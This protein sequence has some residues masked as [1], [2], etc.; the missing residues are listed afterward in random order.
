[1]YKMKPILRLDNVCKSFGGVVAADNVSFSVLPGEIHGLIGPNGAGKS[2]IMNLISGIYTVDS[3]DV[4]LNEEKITQM[5]AYQRAR[6]G[7]GRTFQTPRFLQRSNI[8]DNLLLG[9]DLADQMGY[10]RS[11][12]GKKGY[13]FDD[14]L[15]ELM[16]YVE[17]S[18]DLND[19]ITSLSYGQ[20]KQLEIIR[21]LL[22]H[23]KVMLVDEPA[24]GLNRKEI[25]NVMELLR[26]AAKDRNIGILLIEHSMDM[27]M[28]VCEEIVVINF[29]KVIGTGTPEV[30]SN[31]NAVIEAYLGR[32]RNA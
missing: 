16:K 25:D 14:E 13:A 6:N 12:I 24:A 10:W 28:N 15:R 21:S 1:M 30:V 27:V 22:A 18:F 11:Y 5:P 26:H 9:T 4:Y 32:D 8:R 20:S 29:G 19:D 31:N 7:I 17:F 2:T 23:P 3:G